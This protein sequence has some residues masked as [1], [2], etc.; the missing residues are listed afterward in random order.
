MSKLAVTVDG[1]IY[2][3]EA[4]LALASDAQLEV[5]V[6]GEKLSAVLP[7][8]ESSPDGM[9][10]FIIAG[11][12]YEV[13]VDADLRRMRTRWG[14]YPIEVR[15]LESTATRPP[16]GEGRV[17]APIP[18]QIVQVLVAVGDRVEVGQ[19]L[20]ILEAMKMENEVRA[21]RAGKVTALHVEAGQLVKLNEVLAEIE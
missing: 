19:P 20:L 16:A 11:R 8:P 4:N 14:Q 1:R 18:G 6:D 2:E 21:A 3:I 7:D 17:K 15:D 13:Q 12:P 5:L 10:R 9:A